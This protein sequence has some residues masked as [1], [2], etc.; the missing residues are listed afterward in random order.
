MENGHGGDIYAYENGECLTD[1]S[2]NVNPFGTPPEIIEAVVSG[3][4]MLGRYPDWSCRALRK[5]LAKHIGCN[6]DDVVCGNGAA[7]LIFSIVSAKKPKTALLTAP[8]FAEYERA[9]NAVGAEIRYHMLMPE[10]EFAL[11]A[12]FEQAL[13]QDL[14]M[15]FLCVPN[16]PTGAVLE[17]ERLTA[18]ADICEKNDSLLVLDECFNEFLTAPKAYSMLDGITG[19]SSLIILK[20]FTKMYA[21][22]GLRLGYAV[23]CN[24]ALLEEIYRQRQTWTVSTLAQKAG[25]AALAQTQF[26]EQSGKILQTERKFLEQGIASLGLRVFAGDGNFLLFFG[27]GNWKERLLEKGFLIRDCSNYRGLTKGYYRIAVRMH[28]DNVRL[29]EAM[30]IVLEEGES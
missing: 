28:D 25:L 16:N 6:A 10:N 18:I 19:R 1:F 15:V 9:L 12:D 27:A 4:D 8:C 14:D 7:E 30:R 21:L 17:K 29:L 11:A 20:S 26:A 5:E 24:H 2:T 22:A 23:S 13:T 3:A